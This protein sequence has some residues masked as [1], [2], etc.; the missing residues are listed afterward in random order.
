MPH[1]HF[2]SL[3]VRERWNEEWKDYTVSD[4]I[5]AV[6]FHPEIKEALGEHLTEGG[7]VIEAGCG[8]GGW[9]C[10]LHEQ[11]HEVV[12][13]D[14]VEPVVRK[15]KAALGALPLLVADVENLPFKENVFG[16]YLSLGVVEHIEEGPERAI[17]EAFRVTRPGG[18]LF[19]SVPYKHL[20]FWIDC[21]KAFLKRSRI[22]RRL[23]AK[24]E[25]PRGAFFF[26]HT[27]SRR[28]FLGILSQYHG[29]VLGHFPYGFVVTLYYCFGHLRSDRTKW[30]YRLNPLGGTLCRFFQRRQSWSFGHMQLAVLRKGGDGCQ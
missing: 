21:F 24:S 6:D 16:G 5:E 3:P 22:L 10:Y 18:V 23:L 19:V 14:Y 28:E 9:V 25:R 26:Q 15:A 27:Y 2:D 12:G 7:R 17:A 29:D 1:K 13:V 8:L 30:D 4:K 20:G 11:G